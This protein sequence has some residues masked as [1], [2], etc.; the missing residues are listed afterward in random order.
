M[1][2]K[3]NDLQEKNSSNNLIIIACIML[4]SMFALGLTFQIS[5]TSIPKVCDIRIDNISSFVI[6]SIIGIIYVIA[7]LM[8]FVGGIMAD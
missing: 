7:G 4:F 1:N 6:G 8:T 3:A 5:Q 2:L